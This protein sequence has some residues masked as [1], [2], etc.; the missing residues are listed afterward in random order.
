MSRCGAALCEQVPLVNE[1]L[2]L[3]G[4]RLRP[5]THEDA[6]TLLSAFGDPSIRRYATTVVDTAAAATRFVANRATGWAERT[7]ASWAITDEGTGGV[8]GH[9]GVHVVEQWLGYAMIGYWLLPRGRGRG[10]ATQAVRA[11]TTAAFTHL[12]LHRIELAHA[13]ENVASCAV[14][15]RCGYLYEG[16]LRDAMRYAGEQ[17][18][19]EHLHARL[20]TDES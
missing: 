20:V 16:T 19:T 15:E 10:L 2:E 14:A 12:D 6:E 3:P 13:I 1:I 18:S 17:W 7:G 9:V 8:L 11:G 5:W 4:L